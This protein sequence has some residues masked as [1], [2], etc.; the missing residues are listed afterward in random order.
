MQAYILSIGHELLMGELTDTNSSW[1]ASKLPSLG[2]VLNGIS[3]VGDDIDMLVRAVES[4]LQKAD[5]II[6]T[7]GLGPTQDDLTREA[8]SIAMNETPVIQTEIVEQLKKHFASR[9]Q[10]MPNTN[11][12]Q[13][14]L[15][16]SAKF[17]PNKY[18]TAPGWWV[19]KSGKIIIS[20]PGPPS[21]MHPLWEEQIRPSLQMISNQEIT[22]T[23]TI[24]TMG[25][26]EGKIDEI[27]SPHFGQ[28]NPYLGIY[29]KQDGIHLRIIA[30]ARTESQADSMI[31]PM[32]KDIVD[33]LEEFVWGFDE[34]T[35]QQSIAEHLN[36]IDKTLSTIECGTGG[37]LASTI[38]DAPE[39]DKFYKGGLTVN[40]SEVAIFY[41]VP[42]SIINK[43]GFVS[44]ETANA[45][46]LAV[47]N[48]FGSDY[49]VGIAG[50]TSLESNPS[51][52]TSQ[53]FISISHE[54]TFTEIPLTLA[55]RRV[56]VRRRAANIALI[57]LGKL[58]R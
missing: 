47:R 34:Y 46:S 4:S 33:A 32:E 27:L 12:K 43:H 41:G 22:L 54:N 35:P 40:T 58:L 20:L 26:S 8:I 16:P 6:T 11:I 39:S 10:D 19:E 36:R 56:I 45:M 21:E 2:I 3:I 25:L 14:H 44:Q 30:R 53:I 1:I 18:G 24:K 55:P 5:L 49:G 51:T 28:E 29:S 7:G 31:K 57:E 48:Q 37:I 50:S 42:E 23:R 38:T 17:V 9:G 52:N 15:I 13:A